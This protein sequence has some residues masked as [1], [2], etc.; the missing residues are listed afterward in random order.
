MAKKLINSASLEGYLYEHK[1]EKKVTGAQSKNPGTEY[2]SGTISVATDP[3]CLNVIP[4]HFSYVTEK[5][6]GGKTNRNYSLFIKIINGEVNTVMANG[7]DNAA[8]V[9]VDTVIDLNEFAIENDKGEY[10]IVSAKR[11]E[12]GF[13]SLVSAIS[14]DITKKNFFRQDMLITKVARMEANEEKQLPEKVVLSGYIF[15]FKKEA[16]PVS[17]SVTNVGAMNYFESANISSKEPM[18]TQVWGS[19][20]SQT[21]MKKITTESAFGDTLVT[22]T[23]N[24]RKDYIITGAAKEPYV[25][26]S[27]D[28][29]TAQEVT[30][31]MAAREIKLASIKKNRE[32]YKANKAAATTAPV[33]SGD[34]IF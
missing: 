14:D 19:Q 1:L 2:I 8:K 31:M 11:L 23:P 25:W 4:V 29:L 33:A 22:E 34:Y 10:E 30:E 32:D 16:L 24:T 12:G 28:T 18:F 20:I 7:K 15:N 27:E 13:V 9:H 17:F 26:D 6:S 21:V 5:T 3:D